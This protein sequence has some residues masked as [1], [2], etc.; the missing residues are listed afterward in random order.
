V[1]SS[2]AG[3]NSTLSL[4]ASDDQG[5]VV[6]QPLPL[7]GMIAAG[8]FCGISV[9][10]HCVTLTCKLGGWLRKRKSAVGR[11]V[12]N[13]DDIELGGLEAARERQQQQNLASALRPEV[14]TAGAGQ[15]AEDSLPPPGSL[16]SGPNNETTQG[17]ESG[18]ASGHHLSSTPTHGDPLQANLI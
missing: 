13:D 5:N 7:G 8:V 12:G 6:H 18:F 15:L 10:I 16:T 9:A 17:G 11:R 4:A 3:G 1:L 2:I 14:L